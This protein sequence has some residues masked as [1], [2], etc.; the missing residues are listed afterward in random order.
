MYCVLEAAEKERV[1]DPLRDLVTHE[2]EFKANLLKLC[3]LR[4]IFGDVPPTA[5]AAAPPP[6]LSPPQTPPQTPTKLELMTENAR[7]YKSAEGLVGVAG[8]VVSK[9]LV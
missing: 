9:T 3:V 8:V 1:F 2:V 4:Q 7:F 6:P 5:A